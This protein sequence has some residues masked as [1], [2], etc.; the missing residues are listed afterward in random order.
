MIYLF[1]SVS[2]NKIIVGTTTANQFKFQIKDD[3]GTTI[4]DSWIDVGIIDFNI[5]TKKAKLTVKYS[6]FIDSTDVLTN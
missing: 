6:L 2:P 3:Q 4:S 1:L 5:T